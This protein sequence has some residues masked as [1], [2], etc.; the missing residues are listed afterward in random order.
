[1]ERA[2]KRP[3][4]KG[5]ID[6]IIGPM[7]AGKTTAMMARVRAA[8]FAGRKGVVVK[9]SEDDRYNEGAVI[10]TH[11]GER[12]GPLS[13]TPQRAQVRVV[14]AQ[15][16]ADIKVEADES[17]VGIDEGQFYPD[18]IEACTRWSEDGRW[19]LVAALDGDYR[20]K[21]FGQVC[22]LIPLA[23]HVDKLRAVCMVCREQEAAFTMRTTRQR[24]VKVV[25]G[26]ERYRAACRDCH[27]ICDS[28]S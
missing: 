9:H 8:A 3:G 16:L 17:V 4:R 14:V 21:P 10:Q 27:R 13:E 20:R 1:M 25:G 22:E 26:A 23:E 6:V 7:W 11:A 2:V 24:A 12:H 5:Q 15:Q 19:V 18:L 28:A